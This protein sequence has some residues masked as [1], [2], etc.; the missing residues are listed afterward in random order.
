MPMQFKIFTFLNQNKIEEVI[1]EHNAEPHLRVLQKTLASEVTRMVHN[2]GEL[3]NAEKASRVLFSKNFL[4]EINDIEET[5]FLDIFEGVTMAEINLNEIKKGI[6][7]N[8]GE[9]NRSFKIFIFKTKFF[10][11]LNIDLKILEKWLVK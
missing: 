9:K 8:K 10:F 2:Q 3:D 6:E 1:S 4:S 7:I 5:I 11:L